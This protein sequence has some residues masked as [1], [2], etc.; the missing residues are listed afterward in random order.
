MAN[1]GERGQ[2][3]YVY[4]VNPPIQDP[5]RTQGDY[6]DDQ[7]RAH[8]LYRVAVASVIVAAFSGVAASL[9]AVTALRPSAPPPVRVEC[10]APSA[11]TPTQK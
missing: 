11:P 1:L 7:R 5:W 9:G 2:P 8:R 3:V 10:I 4:I 6:L